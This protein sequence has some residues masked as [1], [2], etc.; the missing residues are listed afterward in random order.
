MT[1][2]VEG[3]EA[4]EERTPRRNLRLTAR[5]GQADGGARRDGPSDEHDRRVDDER[6]PLRQRFRDGQLARAVE[7]H[8][9]RAVVAV[10]QDEH[11]RAVEV[12]GL[13]GRGGD[14]QPAGQQEVGHH[15]RFSQVVPRQ[16]RVVGW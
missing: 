11:H 14:E 7:D 9:E 15:P 1:L 6:L 5:P 16:P 10:L 2:E 3:A 12:G 13:Q 4:V 8:A